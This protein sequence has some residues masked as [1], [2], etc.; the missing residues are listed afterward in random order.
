MNQLPKW[1]LVNHFPAIHDF[2]SLTAIEQTARIYGAMQTLIIEYN[3]FAEAAN[4]QI[5]AFS[6]EET[7][8]RE[9][10]ELEITKVMNEFRCSMEKYLKLNLDE[11]ATQVILEGMNNGSI[12]VP[13]DASLTRTKYPADAAATGEM[14][15]LERARINQLAKLGEGSTT[16]DAELVDI[17][18]AYD[19]EAYPTAGDAVRRQARE[20]YEILRNI[21]GST[22]N[23]FVGKM[24]QGN[25]DANG[26]DTDSTKEY[27][28]RTNEFIPIDSSKLAEDNI[29][30]YTISF[31]SPMNHMQVFF[32]DKNYTFLSADAK[33]YGVE[34]GIDTQRSAFFVIP[35]ECAFVKFKLSGSSGS[36][37]Y[38]PDA[39]R[40]VQVESGYAATEYEFPY[41]AKDDYCR[42]V[43]KDIA[44]NG[45]DMWKYACGNIICFG[46][47]LTDGLYANTA[48]GLIQQ[49]YPYYLGRMLNATVENV[50]KNGSYPKQCYSVTLPKQDISK[51]DTA[52]I[53][54]GTNGGLFGDDIE[55]EGT[56]AN[57]YCKIIEELK[58]K[59]SDI[60]IF[61]CN[62]FVTGELHTGVQHATVTETNNTI[63]TIAANYD[64]PV[65]DM[66]DL[67]ATNHIELHAYIDNTHFGKAGNL[68][69]ANRIAMFMH[70]FFNE[71][72]ARVEFGLLNKP[73]HE[74]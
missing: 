36:N 61:L 68:Y 71:K 30:Y 31:V 19:G 22:K 16:G 57:Y 42:N 48:K 41:T 44:T 73:S 49:N 6:E 59:K 3:A 56:E 21:S 14:I 27:F 18:V 9:E 37:T 29:C 54:L 5:A 13:T 7:E 43:L 72:I 23:V 39:L 2:E 15:A 55:T 65:I 17:R 11:T 4:E 69:I 62:V 60:R 51:Y 52:I 50:G 33:G 8:A 63:A 74:A 1:A 53:W 12:P 25:I 47:S 40:N 70:K 26:V 35:T 28:V 20:L 67:S 64:I 34:G 58:A 66:S 10:F 45:M 46:D 32:Y 24:V 38:T